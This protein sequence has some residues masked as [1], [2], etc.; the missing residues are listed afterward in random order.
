MFF[1]ITDFQFI[2]RPPLASFISFVSAFAISLSLR[3]F[4]DAID[5]LFVTLFRL[6]HAVDGFFTPHV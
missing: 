1:F 3:C 5:W 2:G 4:I 6:R